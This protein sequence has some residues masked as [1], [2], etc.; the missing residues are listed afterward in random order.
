MPFLCDLLTVGLSMPVRVRRGDERYRYDGTTL[1]G[2]DDVP[3]QLPMNS[4]LAGDWSLDESSANDVL[5]A[6]GYTMRNAPGGGDGYRTIQPSG[7]DTW[8]ILTVL[9][10]ES[11]RTAAK[12]TK[13]LDFLDT[14]KP[15]S[16]EV[17]V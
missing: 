1:L 10:S 2:L 17:M 3:V 5:T 15:K 16:A 13:V 4:M 6:R 11:P 8:A 12:M 9:K 14:F 7:K